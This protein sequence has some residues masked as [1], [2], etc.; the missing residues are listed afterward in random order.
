MLK[1]IVFQEGTHSFYGVLKI[2]IIYG[3][4]SIFGA[5]VSK[6][7]S[8]VI[9]VPFHQLAIPIQSD[10]PFCI[11]FDEVQEKEIHL[12][13][14]Q[15]Y[16]FTPDGFTQIL[17]FVYYSY[18]NK[19]PRYPKKLI[20]KINDILISNKSYRIYLYGGKGI[21]KS[22]LSNF[23]VNILKSFPASPEKFQDDDCLKEEEADNIKEKS[24]NNAQEENQNNVQ[25]D[26][27]NTNQEENQSSN[28]NA[29]SKYY[30]FL[31]DQSNDIDDDDSNNDQIFNRKVAFVDFD[32]GQPE[33]SLPT[34]VSYTEDCPFLFGSSEHH[35][36][37]AHE[38][39]SLSSINISNISSNYSYSTFLIGKKFN[40][41]NSSD[42]NELIVINSHGWI[43]DIGF[44][45]QIE[46]IKSMKP[47]LVICLYKNKD[48]PPRK[49]NDNQFNVEIKPIR[50]VVH[51]DPIYLR[52]IRFER[53]FMLKKDVDSVACC[54]YQPISSMVP[55]PFPI[56]QFRYSFP[57]DTNIKR[58]ISQ[59]PRVLNCSLISFCIDTSSY[60][61]EEELLFSIVKPR[62][63]KCC[64]FGFVRAV[65]VSK[66]VI[67]IITP[68]DEEVLKHANTIMYITSNLPPSFIRDSNR[69]YL[70]YN[71]L[72][73]APHFEGK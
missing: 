18:G 63:M 1:R 47:D 10:K 30:H 12:N 50:E 3:T 26:N 49:I 33:I 22:T 39:Y 5:T 23:L 37:L 9:F 36:C 66:Q 58:C 25:E 60:R 43:E 14:L 38:K 4:V 31:D 34:T 24:Q 42:K 59:V 16:D 13:E 32:P 70:P 11:Q 62:V 73:M 52:N 8:D 55:I 44:Q 65:D 64:G 6:G 35:S 72:G 51:L 45:L 27:L 40:K 2:K 61:K 71:M 41:N 15:Y 21:G 46:T 7:F 29:E 53:Y 28:N 56:K 69:F 68:E 57:G 17:P 67:Y 48:R 54:L 20:K 19:G